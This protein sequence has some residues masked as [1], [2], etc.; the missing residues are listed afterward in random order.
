MS[1]NGKVDMRRSERTVKKIAVARA[2]PPISEIVNTIT[3]ASWRASCPSRDTADRAW[4]HY[5][6][7]LTLS[8]TLRGSRLREGEHGVHL[9][10]RA[11]GHALKERLYLL[12]SRVRRAVSG[13]LVDVVL[14]GVQSSKPRYCQWLLAVRVHSALYN[15]PTTT[16]PLSLSPHSLGTTYHSTHISV[17]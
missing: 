15:C 9:D 1:R 3:R 7:T 13:D 10:V 14:C 11:H 8:L 2:L 6:L 12:A 17:N 4:L 16:L 5:P